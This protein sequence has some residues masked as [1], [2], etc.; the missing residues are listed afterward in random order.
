VPYLD[1]TGERDS[2]RAP[3]GKPADPGRLWQSVK[4]DWRWIP[5]A[6]LIWGVLGA[7]VAFGLMQKTYRS[8]AALVW[9]PKGELRPDERTMS[10]EVASI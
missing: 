5:I 2:W 6:A 8:S 4:W 7:G 9:E 1:D 10:A 3:R